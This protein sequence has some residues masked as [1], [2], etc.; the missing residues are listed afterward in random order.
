MLVN[1][2]LELAPHDTEFRTIVADVLGRIETFF[3]KCITAGQADRTITRSVPADNLGPA[4]AQRTYGRT[5][6]G[7]GQA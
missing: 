6:L 5:R 3:L 7:E 2:A 4:S 1:S